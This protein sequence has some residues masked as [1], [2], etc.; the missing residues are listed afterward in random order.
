MMLL[1]CL[2]ANSGR[3]LQ[4]LEPSEADEFAGNLD[5]RIIPVATHAVIHVN[6]SYPRGGWLSSVSSI[7]KI[8]ASACLSEIFKAIV[9]EN[10]IDVVYIFLGPRS[11][12]V[13]PCETMGQIYT[14][15]N[16]NLSI[17]TRRYGSRLVADQCASRCGETRENACFQVVMQGLFQ[18]F[19][20]HDSLPKPR[21]VS[22]HEG[23]RWA[24]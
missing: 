8:F 14:T 11:L 17:S 10:M 18:F 5:L 19:A 21:Y 20:G 15:T 13:E 12:N 6:A 4:R 23:E 9:V 2:G 3:L 7:V 22:C 1:G 16:A 24:R